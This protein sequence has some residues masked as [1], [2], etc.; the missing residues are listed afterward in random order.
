MVKVKSV[1]PHDCKVESKNISSVK[2]ES[3]TTQICNKIFS[4]QHVILCLHRSHQSYTLRSLLLLSDS[5]WQTAGWNVHKLTDRLGLVWAGT[6]L[7]VVSPLTWWRLPHFR[8]RCLAVSPPWQLTHTVDFACV[9]VLVCI[10]VC[11]N[12]YVT[13]CMPVCVNAYVTVCVA[14]WLFLLV[15][16]IHYCIKRAIQI[17]FKFEVYYWTPKVNC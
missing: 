6:S 15:F 14:A 2:G 10:P 17:K 1:P 8:L 13:V 7:S 16:L 4:L 9:S 3:Y 5:T 11:V 12:V